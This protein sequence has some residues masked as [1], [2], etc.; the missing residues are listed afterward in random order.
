MSSLQVS[1]RQ[2]ID[3][4]TDLIGKTRKY[5]QGQRSRSN[6]NQNLIT[7]GVQHKTHIPN[8]LRQFLGFYRATA[9]HTHGL[10]IDVCLSVC[11]SLRLSVKRLHCD[12]PK[13]KSVDISTPY[14]RAMFLVS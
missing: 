3:D 1:Y 8:N 14:D 7:S 6:V 13:Q 4:C 9:K 5:S 11:T 12:K 2:Y 10:A